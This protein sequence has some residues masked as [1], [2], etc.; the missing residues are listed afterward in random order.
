[1]AYNRGWSSAIY[2]LHQNYENERRET[3]ENVV[4]ILWM[5]LLISCGGHRSPPRD[6]LPFLSL[7]EG[8]YRVSSAYSEILIK[9]KGHVRNLYFVRDTGELALESS[10][11]KKEPSLLQVPYTQIMM[12]ALLF[13]SA[14]TTSLMIGLG[15]GGMPHYLQHYHPY[16]KQE[17]VDID[18]E[19]VR[20]AQEY[21]ALTPDASLHFYAADGFDVIRECH[22]TYD[23]LFMDA[24]LKPSEDT[25]S[26]GTHKRLKTVEFY[27]QINEC[28]TQDGVVAFNINRNETIQDDILH[29]IESF[30]QTWVVP[31]PERGNVV[32]FAS[33]RRMP[34]SR[35][36]LFQRMYE[37][38]RQHPSSLSY[39][40]VLL[41]I[42]PK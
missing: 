16:L 28:L 22:N 3:R 38:E 33:K 24:F 37:L 36:V 1:M 6:V 8:E 14:P 20:I 9:D 2:Q 39:E 19:I 18:S 25:D 32:V 4:I 35:E 40:D 7:D 5:A 27:E 21:F 10:I 41:V 15:G 26:T 29:I 17:V 31:V 11:H 30:A 34:L 42:D 23:I 13:H 12:G